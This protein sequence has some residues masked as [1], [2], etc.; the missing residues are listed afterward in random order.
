MF[1]YVTSY[2]DY[3]L[4][5]ESVTSHKLHQLQVTTSCNLHPVFCNLHPVFFLQLAS[6]ILY[7]V[8]CLLSPCSHTPYL[9]TTIFSITSI[10]ISVLKK[11]SRASRGEFTIG[12]FSLKEVFSKMGTPVFFLKASIKA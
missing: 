10:S 4:Q 9:S 6:C 8:S 12:S 2:T 11:Q 3:K 5:V 7:P 1:I